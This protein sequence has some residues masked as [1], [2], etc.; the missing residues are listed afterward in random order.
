MSN[1]LNE[2][3]KTCRD[4]K[5]SRYIKCCAAIYPHI[6]CCCVLTVYNAHTR[7][8]QKVVW[9]LSTLRICCCYCFLQPFKNICIS[10]YIKCTLT[11]PKQKKEQS[12]VFICF[13]SIVCF[14]L[15][16]KHSCGCLKISRT[17]KKR[18]RKNKIERK[19]EEEKSIPQFHTR[20]L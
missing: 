13:P 16:S 2:H 3:H 1:W 11:F 12:S 6:Y 15:C 7:L 10:N 8:I 9:C 20:L 4:T 17:K 18:C 5:Q 14:V 19:T